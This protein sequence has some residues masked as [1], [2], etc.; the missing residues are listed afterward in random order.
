MTLDFVSE[1]KTDF[2]FDPQEIAKTVIGGVLEDQEFKHDAYVSLMITNEDEIRQINFKNRGIDS[3]TDVL[4]F[5]MIELSFFPELDLH[6]ELFYPDTDEVMLGDIVICYERVL[7][8]S[9]EYG[10]SVKRE[11]AFL[12]AH[13]M[14]HLLGYGH[15]D[16]DER[17]E[18]EE[19]QRRILNNLNTTR[20]D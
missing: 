16:E 10:H 7:S 19:I 15:E 2:D 4:S 20:E 11:Y 14:L 18:M 1:V 13:S 6:D 8:Q 5:P 17:I 12:I 3:V 9:K